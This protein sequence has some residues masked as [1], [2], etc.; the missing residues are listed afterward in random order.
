MP[1]VKFDTNNY[2]KYNIYVM[3]KEI[4]IFKKGNKIYRIVNDIE[5]MT[6]IINILDKNGFFPDKIVKTNVHDKA[7][8]ILESDYLPTII[9]SGEFTPSMLINLTQRAI[10]ITE[11]LLPLRVYPFDLVPHNFTYNNGNWAFYDFDSFSLNKNLFKA[12]IRSTFKVTFC[13]FEILK[14][15]K[16]SKLN[17][18]FLNRISHSEFFKMVPFHSF[19]SW[20]TKLSICLLLHN[21]NLNKLAL[22][23]IKNQFKKYK[24]LF[25]PVQ[26]SF[27]YE[28]ND[29]I[30]CNIIDKILN[31]NSINSVFAITKKSAKWSTQSKTLTRK[32]IYLDNYDLCDK[33]YN[34]I[35]QNN[36]K[37]ISTAV[38]YPFMKDNEIPEKTAYKGIY[39]YFA[40]ERF[41]ANAVIILDSSELYKNKNFDIKTFC[42]NIAEFSTQLHVQ[43]F[44]KKTEVNLAQKI[45][46]ELIKYY[47]NTEIIE[48]NDSIIL[49][50]KEKTVP[51]TNFN[52][53]PQYE[54]SNRAR[55]AKKHSK[56]II[57][58]L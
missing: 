16:R 25:P 2:C 36:Y 17:H 15:L 55:E 11:S 47:K 39:D 58:L 51:L 29:N 44:D 13:A 42:K 56:E 41:N 12:Q 30:T 7:N 33:F 24:K 48:Q 35:H 21:L 34:F 23:L 31:E 14:K 45:K 32:F 20:M 37:N 3:E 4:R 54:N 1:H 22:K 18:Y 52:E 9:H 6:Q 46:N 38:V 53:L 49:I 40:Q 8:K 27:S 26:L 43:I 28:E 57:K 5:E 19:L 50:A 10:D